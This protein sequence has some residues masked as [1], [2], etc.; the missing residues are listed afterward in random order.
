[1]TI[2]V[3]ILPQFHAIVQAN[4][5]LDKNGK[6]M[7]TNEGKIAG[8]YIDARGIT[9]KDAQGNDVVYFD[10]TGIHWNKDYSPIKYQFSTSMSGPWHDTYAT[11]DE[12][13]RESFDGGTTWEAPYKLVGKDGQPGR[14]GA[15]G[16]DATVPKYITD[17][18]IAK[19]VIEAPQINATNF[20]IYPASPTQ[21]G[22]LSLH[23]D[24]NGKQY[25]M[26]ELKYVVTDTPYIVFYSPD[27]AYAEWNF[28]RSTFRGNIDFS[29]ANVSGIHATFA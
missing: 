4:Q 22:S 29:G 6:D 14:D 3:N 19:G 25:N 9:I 26:F 18:V 20:G 11:N 28:G 2:Y 13:R 23:G 10:E 8:E 5:F 21:N 7:F 16:S 1:M 17:T 15:D 12:Y 27:G 24:Y